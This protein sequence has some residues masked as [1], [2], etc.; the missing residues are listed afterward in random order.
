M[1]IDANLL[2]AMSKAMHDDLVKQFNESSPL[3]NAMIPLTSI[4]DMA[5]AHP[6]G[7]RVRLIEGPRSGG[8]VYI[9][10]Y[11]EPGVAIVNRGPGTPPARLGYQHIRQGRII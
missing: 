3:L 8:T 2:T 7:T 6:P 4:M 11:T 10:G 1:T 5:L 9:E